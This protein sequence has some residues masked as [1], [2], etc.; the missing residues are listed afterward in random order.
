MA[1]VR[2]QNYLKKHKIGPLLESLMAR[3]IQDM[4]DDPIGY[5]LK[6]LQ[7][8]HEKQST[9]FNDARESN[10]PRPSSRPSTGS[11]D[12]TG[13][14]DNLAKSWSVGP[15]VGLHEK[16]KKQN[17]LQKWM[18]NDSQSLTNNT[19]KS[20]NLGRSPKNISQKL[21][22]WN[23]D[24]RVATHD[25]DELFQMQSRIY[26][27]NDKTLEK[28]DTEKYKVHNWKLNKKSSSEENISFQPSEHNTWLENELSLGPK[29]LS[30]VN[31]AQVDQ[32][33]LRNSKRGNSKHNHQKHKQDLQAL[34]LDVNESRQQ[35][36]GSIDV[37]S[38][39]EY[40]TEILERIEDLQQEG[41]D[42]GKAN[43][44]GEQNW[45]KHDR[46]KAIPQK[47][48][49]RRVRKNI[50][51]IDNET[52]NQS[53]VTND[54]FSAMLFDSLTNKKKDNNFDDNS[55]ET[56]EKIFNTHINLRG[57]KYWPLTDSENESTSQNNVEFERNLR[58]FTPNGDRKASRFR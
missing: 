24:T 36:K 2:V 46:E 13:N 33:T 10:S 4:P 56:S 3:V 45:R 38:L 34:L 54:D 28:S 11:L 50:R 1:A 18:R 53:K 30:S 42:C 6:V 26:N 14:S 21:P 8:I 25:F 49:A 43:T 44:E 19:S 17:Q 48:Y 23:N 27:I 41:F 37:S 35:Q 39:P 15:V 32:I 57:Q 51:E 29:Q 31:D 52:D 9:H 16:T 40:G 20:L 5:F 58:R 7:N 22:P 47:T 55:S 12:N